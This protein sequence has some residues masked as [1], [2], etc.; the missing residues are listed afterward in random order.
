MATVYPANDGVFRQDNATCHVSKIVRAWFEEH[1][2]EFQLLPWP[3]N[4]QISTLAKIC[5]NICNDT[6]DRKTLHLGIFTS[7][8]ILCCSHGHRCLSPPSKYTL[9]P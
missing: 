9:S 4:S 1:N 8:A 2:E 7:Y 6:S 5:G 3:P